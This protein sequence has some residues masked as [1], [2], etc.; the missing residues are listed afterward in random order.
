MV[1]KPTFTSLGIPPSCGGIEIFS[2]TQMTA[3]ACARS[4]ELAMEGP[5]VVHDG[6]VKEVKY[7]SD[8]NMVCRYTR[9]GKHTKKTMENHHRK[10]VDFPINSM[11][12]LSMAKCK[13]SPE[14]IPMTWKVIYGM[15]V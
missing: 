6:S 3:R 2:H 10:F 11:V 14:G 8:F 7:Q 9:P 5:D 13:R 1:Y 12:D 15:F 4:Q